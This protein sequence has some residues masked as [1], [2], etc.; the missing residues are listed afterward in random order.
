MFQAPRCLKSWYKSSKRSNL[1]PGF[2]KGSLRNWNVPVMVL[3]AQSSLS[4][5]S[6]PT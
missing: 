1:W 6:F 3:S 2:T 5:L 4:G